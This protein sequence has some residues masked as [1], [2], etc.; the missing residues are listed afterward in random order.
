MGVVNPE[1]RHISQ[2]PSLRFARYGE[3]HSICFE[4]AEYPLNGLVSGIF[5][6]SHGYYKRPGNGNTI[7]C[8]MLRKRR[9]RDGGGEGGGLL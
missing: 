9:G 7:M 4:N 5:G 2:E 6:A 1:T 3:R 8:A